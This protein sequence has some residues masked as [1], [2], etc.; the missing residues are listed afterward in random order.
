MKILV[1]DDISPLGIEKLEA[2]P[3]A[4]VRVRTGMTEA[5]L[6]EEIRD[7]DAL[8]VRSQTKVT[9]PVLAAANQ[10]KVIGRAG[11]G[12]DNIDIP[13]A[14]RRGVVVINAPDGNTISAAEHTF[15][16]LI[17]MSRWIPAADRSIRA[18]K[19]DRKSF[20]GVEL[21]G[22][23]LAVLGT[24]RIGAEVAKRAKVFGM[25]VLGFDPYL[26]E[27]RAKELGITRVSFDEAIAAADFITVHTPLTKETKHML[28]TS[29][30]AK[31]K[32][33]VRIVNCARGGIIDE[34]A[35]ADALRAGKVASAAI[36]VF[37]SEPLASDHPL[38]EFDNVVLTPHLGASTVEA[39]ENV[40]ID[41][42]EQVGLLLEGKPFQNAV[43]LP[44]L[45][46][47]L[48]AFLEPY[49]GLG[50]QLGLFA[51]QWVGESV[52][53]VEIAF[54]GPIADHDVSFVT[55]TVLKG[56]L[57]YRYGDEAN[58]VNAPFL[59]EQAGI[60]VRE[61]KQPHSKVF[62]NL[63]TLTVRSDK[64]EHR[65]A[66][67]LYNGFGPRIVEIDGYTVDAAPEGKMLL[68]RHTDKPGMIGRIGSIL[69]DAEIN[70][71]A[72]QVGRRETGGEAVMVLCVD[73]VISDDVL[74]RITDVDGIHLA[75]AV[76]L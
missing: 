8:L 64:G 53:E 11:V 58:Y 1:A 67:T 69:G 29:A 21:R 75:R 50:E 9:A 49:L 45:S 26:T 71:G 52:S 70:I 37:E 39:Q 44:S 2:L 46:G 76:D 25:T 41:V 59:A 22:K 23:T 34:Q 36:D 56:W 24:G 61:V 15:A 47:E 55:R 6:T 73:K 4:T 33:G 19:W 72:M 51:G 65:V 17:A 10:L 12:V 27:A 68:T 16:M 43:N 66:G 62:T 63:L 48:K 42:A 3:G 32:D 40:A 28:G 7:T 14:T 60:A 31:M 20:V 5:E 18:G 38:R 13:A 35:L 74:T 30:F 54:A 57:G